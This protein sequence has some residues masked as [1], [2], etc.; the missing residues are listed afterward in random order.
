MRRKYGNIKTNVDGI[1]FDS[2]GEANRWCELLILQRIGKISNLR[3]QVPF[4]LVDG[5]VDPSGAKVRE[6]RL[7]IDF[8]YTEDGKEV[9][10]DF[11]SPATRT[12]VFLLKKKLFQARYPHIE[13]RET[14]A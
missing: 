11:K 10:E 2:R 12:R 8:G 5:F 13:F 3:R 14:M 7:V 9:V 4:V 6:T 1:K